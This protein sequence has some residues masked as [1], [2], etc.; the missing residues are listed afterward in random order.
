MKRT[1]CIGF[2]VVA[3]GVFASTIASARFMIPMFR[4]DCST[5]GTGGTSFWPIGCHCVQSGWVLGGMRIDDNIIGCHLGL[6][7][8]DACNFHGQC[9]VFFGGGGG[10][11]ISGGDSLFVKGWGVVGADSVG[12]NR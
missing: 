5:A 3:A 1:L 6:G 4:L 8:N 12:N 2:L 10:G 11:D 9:T 7:E